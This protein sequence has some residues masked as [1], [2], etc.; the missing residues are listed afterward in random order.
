MLRNPANKY[1]DVN[2]GAELIDALRDQV[3]AIDEL[4]RVNDAILTE[5]RSEREFSGGNHD[6]RPG[7]FLNQPR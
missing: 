3:R 5:L 6:D 2:A 1:P 4:V 7:R